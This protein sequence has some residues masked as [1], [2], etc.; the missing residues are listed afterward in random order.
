MKEF[1]QRFRS[2]KSAKR[3]TQAVQPRLE[4]LEDR[5]LL[6]STTGEKFSFGSRITYSFMPDGTN[7]AGK[8]SN[9]V[10]Q[11]DS[12][13]G[14][15]AWQ[16]AFALAAAAWS[17][18]AN[19]NL[20]QVSDNGMPLSAGNYQQGD[21]GVGDIRIGGNAMGSGTLAYAFNPP[22]ANGGSLA[23]DQL[24]NT[25][26]NWQ[27]GKDFDIQ[28]V[29]LHEFGHAL[30]LGHSGVNSA[31]MYQYYS[32]MR[33]NLTNDDIAGVQAVWGVRT[34]DWTAGSTGNDSLNTAYDA[35]PHLIKDYNQA[36]LWDLNLTNS[37][38]QNW[39][40]VTTPANASST[41]SAT[42][43][44]L[45]LSLLVPRVTIFNANGQGLTQTY[46]SISPT[47]SQT[48]A[49]ITNAQPNTTYYVRVSSGLAGAIG[50]GAYALILNAGTSTTYVQPPP[51]TVVYAQPDQGGGSQSEVIG[52][53]P[54]AQQTPGKKGK[55]DRQDYGMINVGSVT[56]KGDGFE[57]APPEREK[58]A[59]RIVGAA[60]PSF[61]GRN[62]AA[63]GQGV[64]V[65]VGGI[66]GRYLS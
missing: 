43:Q 9:F 4:G 63:R 50:A 5:M 42:A 2:S 52:P 57:V 35:T 34:S 19:V 15:A 30:G 17:G 66:E 56:G 1:A 27:L 65:V 6:Y 61:V 48:T 53:A 46:G 3:A 10:S 7:V 31:A 47:G 59:R 22:T 58:G 11:M 26:Q 55:A 13:F 25:N 8:A 36:V 29:A 62:R 41:F 18:A 14:R 16:Q 24:F 21:P 23:S 37:S 64:P 60:H 39:Y 20:V 49:S 45:G 51:N 33:T 44:S 54:K 28:T 32:G 38:D 12:R 40:K